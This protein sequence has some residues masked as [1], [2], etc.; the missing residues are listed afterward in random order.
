MYN[1]MIDNDNVSFVLDDSR[2]ELIELF[3]NEHYAKQNEKMTLKAE[4][5]FHGYAI[6]NAIRENK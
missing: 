6:Y 4:K 1:D 3:Y 5:E 2:K